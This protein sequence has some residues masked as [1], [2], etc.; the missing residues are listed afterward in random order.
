[1]REIVHLAVGQCGNQIG[2]KVN[3]HFSQNAAIKTSPEIKTSQKSE[4]PIGK[5]SLTQ[6]VVIFNPK[7]TMV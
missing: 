3:N 7:W 2:A 5:V 1:M 4:V 6:Y